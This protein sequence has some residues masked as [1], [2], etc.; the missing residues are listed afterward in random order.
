MNSELYIQQFI[1]INKLRH[2]LGMS[3]ICKLTDEEN[4]EI[5]Q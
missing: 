3:V 1:Q 5:Y 4:K 2:L